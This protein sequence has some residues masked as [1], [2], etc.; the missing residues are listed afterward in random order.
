MPVGM[1]W[2]R[3]AVVT[4]RPVVSGPRSVPRAPP[5]V[6][7]AG[8]SVSLALLLL[9]GPRRVEGLLR[10]GQL[11]PDRLVGGQARRLHRG[12]ESMVPSAQVF[13]LATQRV[14]RRFE[15]HCCSPGLRIEDRPQRETPPPTAHRLVG[16]RGGEGLAVG[17]EGHGGH[18][19]LVALEG[20][21]GA[22]RRLPQ[23]QL[24]RLALILL[25]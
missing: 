25:P 11:V 15:A 2:S 9:P 17:A 19:A 22:R 8:R 10:L 13:N 23:P 4:F 5:V 1:G 3:R 18:R 6:S 14:V 16:A 20:G 21:A 12:Q 24:A 7:R